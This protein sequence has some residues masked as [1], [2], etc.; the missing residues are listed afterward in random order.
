MEQ[1]LDSGLVLLSSFYRTHGHNNASYV[2]FSF[3]HLG[4]S[5]IAIQLLQLLH[6]ASL[7]ACLTCSANVRHAHLSGADHN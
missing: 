5:T 4:E 3:I 2:F 7:R 6:I 1:E